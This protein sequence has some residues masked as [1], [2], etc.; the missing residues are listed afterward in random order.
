MKIDLNKGAYIQISGELG[1]YNSLPV[2]VLVKMAQDFQELLMNIAHYDLETTEAVDYNNFKIELLDFQPGSAVPC[3]GFSSRTENMAGFH[4][5]EHRKQVNEKLNNLAD[6]AST[7][8]YYRL[9]EIYTNPIARNQIVESFYS[10]TNNFGNSPVYFV[11]FDKVKSEIKPISPIL[12][13]KKSVKDE[14]ISEIVDI[15]TSENEISEV[16]GFVRITKKGNKTTRKIINAYP[17]P[18]YALSY[19]PSKI[20]HKNVKYFLHNPLRCLF[21]KED[22]YFY[23]QSEILDIIGTGKNEEDAKLSFAEE[24]NYLYNRLNSLEDSELTERFRIIKI[25]INNLVER[26]EK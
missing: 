23:I 10:F 16:A 8:D 11:E 22:G 17:N 2:D 9:K 5:L 25:N 4:T 15:Q 19:S 7:G 20:E 14:L 3:F 26:I 24:F 18:E 12:K 13:I 21:A 1:K 6:I